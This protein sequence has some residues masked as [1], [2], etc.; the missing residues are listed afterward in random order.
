MSQ[1]LSGRLSSMF[2]IEENA[3]AF[4]YGVFWFYLKLPYYAQMNST[5]NNYRLL[6]AKSD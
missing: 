3:N 1:G 4:I 5:T 2:S 6:E